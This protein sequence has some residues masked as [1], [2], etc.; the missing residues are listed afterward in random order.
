MIGGLLDKIT[1]SLGKSYVFAGLLPAAVL[2][3][4]VDCYRNGFAQLWNRL[5]ATSDDLK[6][7]TAIGIEWLIIGFILFAVRSWIFSQLQTIP[8]GRFGLLLLRRTLRRRDEAYAN[9]D[10]LQWKYTVAQWRTAQFAHDAAIF[11]PSIIKPPALAAVMRKSFLA[12]ARLEN[13]VERNKVYP[14]WRDCKTVL[15]GLSELFAFV[16]DKPRFQQYRAQ[17]VAELGLW[18]ALATDERHETVLSKLADYVQRESAIAFEKSQ[19]YAEGPWVY[20]TAIGNRLAALDDYA[21]ARYGMAT[22]TMWDRLWWVLPDR[23]RQEIADARLN[24]ETLLNLGAVLLLSAL[25]IAIAVIAALSHRLT[26]CPPDVSV[27]RILLGLVAL[28]LAIGC[29]RGAIFATDALATKMMTLIDTNRLQLLAGLGF[30][31]K[32]VTEEFGLLS[33]LNAFFVQAIARQ[34]DRAIKIPK[35]GDS[36]NGEKP[37]KS[38]KKKKDDAGAAAADGVEP[39]DDP[40][41][42]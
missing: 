41:D 26:G 42:T 29:Y 38:G 36:D 35:S 16:A 18:R 17:I 11:L 23:G 25:G 10:T 22:G 4:I 2:L 19:Q 30:V 40:D 28:I 13:M 33:E 15:D 39:E 20:P 3:A 14:G 12:R 24:V 37:E 6:N 27:G 21:E 34:P 9:A 1:A 8:R 32:T 7:I 31:P 5:P